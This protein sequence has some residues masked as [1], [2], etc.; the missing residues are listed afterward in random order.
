MAKTPIKLLSTVGLA[1]IATF[2]GHTLAYE[3]GDIIIRGGAAIVEPNESSSTIFIENP[4]LGDT[5]IGNIKVGTDTQLGLS[6][7]Y[8]FTS[9][10]GLEVLAATPFSHDISLPA[11][12]EKIASTKHLPPT[13]TLNWHM[14]EP[15]AKFQPYLGVGFNYTV[16]FDEKVT[17][18]L[19]NAGT[20]EAL[21]AAAAG[22]PVGITSVNDTSI[23]LD[24]SFGLAVH[25]GFDYMLT[26]DLA[27]NL[28]YY[29]IQ[30]DTDATITTNSNAGPIKATAKVNIDPSVY[31]AGISYRF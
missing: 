16:F 17:P 5:G 20:F 21:A 15:S 8:M 25:A 10:L 7:T 13:V 12:N 19:D 31:I 29:R 26:D 14:N 28:S 18:A 11:L 24:D 6:G 3:A 9:N 27:L 23:D 30:L 2:S 22:A 4:A 1:A